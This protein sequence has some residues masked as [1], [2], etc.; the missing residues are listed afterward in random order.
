MSQSQITTV[1]ETSRSLSLHVSADE[2]QAAYAHK[3]EGMRKRAKINGFRPGKVP[4]SVVKKMYGQNVLAEVADTLAN[5]KLRAALA[6][7]KIEPVSVGGV[8]SF[9]EKPEQE[10]NFN[11]TFDVIPPFDLPECKEVTVKLQRGTVSD[12]DVQ[13]TMER[14]RHNAPDYV[15]VERPAQSGDFIQVDFVYCVTDSTEPV[16]LETNTA[17]TDYTG[18][19]SNQRWKLGTDMVIQGM[20][21]ALLGIVKDETRKL[22]LSIGQEHANDN[23]RGKHIHMRV[24]ALAV[25]EQL[26]PQLD[27]AF[28][29]KLGITDTQDPLAEL[30]SRTRKDLENRLSARLNSSNK[31]LLFQKLSDATRVELPQSVIDSHNRQMRRE[32]VARFIPPQELHK[33]P[34]PEDRLKPE[35]F[36]DKAQQ[37]AKVSEVINALVREHKIEATKE[38]INDVLTT[39]ASE[40]EDPQGFIDQVSKNQ[41]QMRHFVLLALEDATYQ[42]LLQ[43]CTIEWEDVTMEQVFAE[44]TNEHS[45]EQDDAKPAT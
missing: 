12:A 32:L 8:D 41:Q 31:N 30:A 1:S 18:S 11:V 42:W 21:G 40:Y 15:V 2:L 17:N 4:L 10:W 36:A 25:E 29:R 23:W 38:Q 5:Q 13:S 35:L 26:L 20:E 39:A 43:Q 14:M 33:D 6:E 9:P 16:A 34:H 7:H 22:C 3:L 45:E 28:A 44:D 19:Y 24:T 27:A 37:R